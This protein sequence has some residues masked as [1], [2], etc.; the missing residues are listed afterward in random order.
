MR[1]RKRTV[2]GSASQPVASRL[3]Y[4]L[5][6]DPFNVRHRLSGHL[7]EVQ[8]KSVVAGSLR[9]VNNNPLALTS[10]ARKTSC[11]LGW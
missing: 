7:F 11:R 6:S 5:A 8:Y 1:G 3:L 2:V 9:S 4:F 10:L